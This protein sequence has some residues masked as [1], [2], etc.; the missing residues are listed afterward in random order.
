MQSAVFVSYC[1]FRV[2][3]AFFPLGLEKLNQVEIRDVEG[4][5]SWGKGVGGHWDG[6][7]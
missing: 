2:S 6:A 7:E 3:E 1:Y 5:I 4:G